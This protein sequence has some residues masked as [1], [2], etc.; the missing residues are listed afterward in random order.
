M[1][2]TNTR[3]HILAAVKSFPAMSTVTVKVL[4]L[5]RDPNS[6]YAKIEGAIR[7]DPGLTANVLKLANSAYFG[8]RGQ[9]CRPSPL[10]TA[11]TQRTQRTAGRIHSHRI[12][13]ATDRALFSA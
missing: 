9:V 7:Y 5:L 4:H 13:Q 11:E 8:L 1:A 6:D 10:L 12:R 3:E 2:E